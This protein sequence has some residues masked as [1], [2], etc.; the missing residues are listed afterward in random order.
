MYAWHVTDFERD[1]GE[2]ERGFETEEEEEEE[3]FGTAGC[4]GEPEKRAWLLR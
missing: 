1:R 4:G 3:G 2:R